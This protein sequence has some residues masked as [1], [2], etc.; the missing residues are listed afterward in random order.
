MDI[1]SEMCSS[2]SEISTAVKCRTPSKFPNFMGRRGK[3]AWKPSR[4]AQNWVSVM[5]L[6]SSDKAVPSYKPQALRVPTVGL[7]QWFL[8][9]FLVGS[10]SAWKFIFTLWTFFS[11]ISA[12]NADNCKSCTHGFRILRA[13]WTLEEVPKP[14]IINRVEKFLGYKVPRVPLNFQLLKL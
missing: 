9:L 10:R 3:R 7:I 4:R 12:C 8:P 2:H 13:S 14:C 6:R 11:C 1:Y 5:I